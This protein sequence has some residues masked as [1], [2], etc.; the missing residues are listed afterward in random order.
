M[1][2]NF[3]VHFT[4]SGVITIEAKN[5]SEAR[6]KLKNSDITSTQ[7]LIEAIE[8]NIGECGNA[9]IDITDTVT[10]QDEQ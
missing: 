6:E 9:C 10:S 8:F 3:E 7:E 5:E 1:M 2:K 4:I